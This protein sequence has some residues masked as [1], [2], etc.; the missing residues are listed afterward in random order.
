MITKQELKKLLTIENFFYTS[1]IGT[2]YTIGVYYI[3]KNLKFLIKYP[4]FDHLVYIVLSIII[5]ALFAL[6][7]VEKLKYFTTERPEKDKQYLVTPKNDFEHMIW[8]FMQVYMLVSLFVIFIQWHNSIALIFDKENYIKIGIFLFAFLPF[9]MDAYKVNKKYFIYSLSV[10][11]ITFGLLYVDF[12]NPGCYRTDATGT[13]SYI[14][15]C[16]S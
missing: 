13:S 1:I 2:L 10:L 16:Q 11:I 4:D 6:V 8:F 3:L 7:Y 15:D 12:F 14:T 5:W 9:L